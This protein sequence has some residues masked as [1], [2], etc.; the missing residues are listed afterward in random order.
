MPTEGEALRGCVVQ[1]GWVNCVIVGVFLLISGCRRMQEI[2]GEIIE[3]QAGQEDVD[4]M[5]DEEDRGDVQ[6]KPSAQKAK[7]AAKK[8]GKQGAAKQGKVAEEA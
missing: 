3:R 6:L 1:T 7:R 5:D 2:Y 8:K 4:D